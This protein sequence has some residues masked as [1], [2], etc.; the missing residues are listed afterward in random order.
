MTKIMFSGTTLKIRS[1]LVLDN[2]DLHF[3][4][5]EIIGVVGNRFAGKNY[6]LPMLPSFRYP[7]SGKITIDDIDVFENSEIMTKV[8]YTW[9]SET[10]H[11]SRRVINGLKLSERLRPNWDM[12]YANELLTK[13]GLSP[14]EKIR[15]LSE[16]QLAIF[17]TVCGLASR[18]PVTVFDGTFLR[19]DEAQRNIFYEE[20]QKDHKLHPRTIILS[21]NDISEIESFIDDAVI[22]DKGQII[23]HET[24]EKITESAKEIMELKERPTLQEVFVHFTDE[25]GADDEQ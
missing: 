22:L 1:K 9:P 21:T 4:G 8:A 25:G 17:N 3:E 2:I 13:F 10:L 7:S 12:E 20:V 16:Q 15:K 23:A 14:K 18:A 19:L 11:N 6:L 5:D 24:V